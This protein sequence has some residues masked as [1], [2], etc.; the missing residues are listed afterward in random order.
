MSETGYSATPTPFQN[1]QLAFF[2]IQPKICPYHPVDC[3]SFRKHREC[4]IR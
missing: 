3:N 1:A 4:H 2:L